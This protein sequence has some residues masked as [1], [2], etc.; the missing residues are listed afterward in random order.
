[1][2]SRQRTLAALDCQQPD[3]VPICELYM[4]ESSIVNIARLLAPQAEHVEAAKDRFGQ[5]RREVLDLYCFIVEELALDATCSNFSIGIER[6]END[7]GRDKYGTIYR[8]SEHGEP[9]PMDGPIKEPSDLEGFDM[10]S[11]LHAGDFAAPKQVIDGAGPSK[12]HFVCITDPFKVSWR[13]R[14]SMQNLLMDY[15]LDPELVHG[16]ARVAT[17]FDIAAIDIAID[18]GANA[19]IVPGD[20]AG[21]DTTIISPRH[22][23]EYIRPY[24]KELVDHAHSKGVKIVK[25]SDGNIWPILDDLLAVGF[26]GIHPIQPQCMDI[27]EVKEHLRGRACVLGNIDC[28][29]LLPFGTEEEVT[30]SVKETIEMAAPGGGYIISSSNSI[31]PGC[32]AENY[33]AMVRAAHRYGRYDGEADSQP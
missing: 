7:V 6:L 29:N 3:R 17:D 10:V 26:D 27:A 2:D 33:I 21:E 19:I 4:N 23:R 1:M 13:R 15:V 8:L 25:H 18:T 9:T 31:H 12:A 32:K 30:R 28:R 20:L 11:K 14:G 16:L 24:H 22:Y 5:E